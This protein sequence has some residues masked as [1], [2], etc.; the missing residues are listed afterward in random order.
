MQPYRAV[1]RK[2]RGIECCRHRP[3]LAALTLFSAYQ[4]QEGF[5]LELEKAPHGKL[6]RNQPLL[7][8]LQHMTTC[9]RSQTRRLVCSG[10]AVRQRAQ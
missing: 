5:S 1:F 3:A 10:T 4:K 7:R 6:W 9:E 2:H 8:E